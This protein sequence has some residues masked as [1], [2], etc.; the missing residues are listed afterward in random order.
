MKTTDI[1]WHDSVTVKVVRSPES[2]VAFHV[3][4]PED[5]QNEVY[6]EKTIVFSEVS[7]YENHEGPFSG[8]VT[9]LAATEE[10][11]G[12]QRRLVRLDTNAG[13]REIRCMDIDL[14]DGHVAA[15]N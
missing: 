4:Y 3:E 2:V 1:F 10:V 5:W 9:I 13:Y 15:G 11:D 12:D 6:V 8:S 14:R 7:K